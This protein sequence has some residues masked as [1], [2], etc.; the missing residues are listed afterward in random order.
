MVVCFV[1]IGRN[2]DH[3]SLNILFIGVKYSRA[4][5]FTPWSF[6]GGRVAIFGVLF[7]A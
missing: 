4:L 3:H 7:C 2:V 6:G 1:D 5:R